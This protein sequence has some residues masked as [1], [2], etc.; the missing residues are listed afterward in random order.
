MAAAAEAVEV[1]LLGGFE[2]VAGGSHVCLPA[3]AERLLALLALSERPVSRSRVAG[4]LWADA[5]EERAGGN[6]R[7][8]IWRLRS[9]GPDLVESLG[10]T[11]RLAPRVGV[12]VRRL[13][14]VVRGL[15][16]GGSPPEPGW[17][18][19]ELCRE[20]LPAWDDDWVVVERERVRQLN[21]HGLESLCERLS[22]Q[23]RFA[24]AISAGLAAV[25]AE[26]LRESAHRSLISAHVAEG[27][28]GEAIAQF[29]R[30]SRLLAGELGLSPSARITALIEPLTRR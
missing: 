15:I 3:C 16:A 22:G 29:R 19:S 10:S 1:R 23:G 2:V 25:V 9:P 12:D 28:F 30:Y 26:P 8:T 14:G 27:N 7:T 21:L 18:L 11:L 6:L 20:L 13:G 24:E 17:D 5:G 4:T